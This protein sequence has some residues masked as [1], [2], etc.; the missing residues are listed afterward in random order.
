MTAN[1]TYTEEEVQKLVRT[2]LSTATEGF[3]EWLKLETDIVDINT[4]EVLDNA[5]ITLKEP[6]KPIS[7]YIYPRLR[8]QG[9]DFEE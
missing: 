2:T 4:R 1:K 6:H 7:D 9:I 8:E 3:L 5:E